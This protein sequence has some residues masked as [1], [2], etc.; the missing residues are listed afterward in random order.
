MITHSFS[1]SYLS[2]SLKDSRYGLVNRTGNLSF[3]RNSKAYCLK[4]R[5]FPFFQRESGMVSSSF[6]K[7]T[8]PYTKATN[9]SSNP[10]EFSAK[11]FVDNLRTI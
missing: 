1:F 5:I 3:R 2:F 6:H 8:R 10:G 4:T 7:D 11:R 9:F